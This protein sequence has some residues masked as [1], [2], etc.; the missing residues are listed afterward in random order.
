MTGWEKQMAREKDM[1]D[2]WKNETGGRNMIRASE[3]CPLITEECDK[4]LESIGYYEKPAS[5]KFHGCESGDLYKH[6][7]VV[8]EVLAD[9]TDKLHLKW[10]RKESP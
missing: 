4:W 6:S 9:L 2:H 5:T 8:A 10:E 3:L 7:A 1:R